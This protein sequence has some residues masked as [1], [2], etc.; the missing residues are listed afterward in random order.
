MSVEL[1]KIAGDMDLILKILEGMKQWANLAELCTGLTKDAVR[2]IILDYDGSL[3]FWNYCAK[4]IACIHNISTKNL[5]HLH[6][7]NPSTAT[8]GD[9]GDISNLCESGWFD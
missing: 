9:E 7:N 2:N 4:R 1:G 5:F 8:L 6:G 3:K